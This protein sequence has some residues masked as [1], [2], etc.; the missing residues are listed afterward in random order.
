MA[1]LQALLQW[2]FL[3]VEGLFNAAFGDRLNPLYHLGAITFFLFWLVAGSGLYLYAFFETGVAAAYASMEAITHGQWFAGGILRSLH[4]YASDAMVLTMLLHLLRHFA[5]DRFRGYR[6]F[7]WATGV[8]L[9]WLV[10]ASGINGYMLPWDRLAQFVITTT[11]EWLD[12]LPGLGG[13]LMRNFTYVSSVSDRFFSLLSFL[14]IG[15]PLF[16]LLLM[17][18]HVQRVPKAA[19]MPPRPVAAGLAVALLALALVR[20]ALSQGGAADLANAVAAVDLDWFYL[21]LLPLVVAWTP[22]QVWLLAGAGSLLLVL[23]P[24]WPAGRAA[25]KAEHQ[26]VVHGAGGAQAR[27]RVRAGE[28]L[29]DAGLRQGLA[30]PYECRNG[31]CGVCICSVVQGRVAHRPYQR[32]ALPDAALADGRALLCCA[33]PLEDVGIE[34]DAVLQAA[35][36]QAIHTARVEAMERLAPDVMRLWLALPP[37]ERVPFTAGQYINILLDDGQRRAFSF[38]NAPHQDQRIELH[39]RRIPGGRFTSHVFDGMRVGDTLR[40][41]GPLGS[42]VLHEGDKP[43]LLVAAATGFAPIKSIVEDAFHRGIRRPMRLYWG[44]RR[45]QDLYLQELVQGWERDHA[46][47]RA[48]PVVSEP[49][50]SDE[51]RGRTGLV[52]E[53]MLADF[54]DLSGHQVYVCGSARMADAA[55]QAFLSRGLDEGACFSD[56]FLPAMQN[57]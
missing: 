43:I 15:L 57:V 35:V 36:A 51:W 12:A 26:A 48:V 34:V 24:W 27:V 40:F 53:A 38:A 37:G 13:T 44:V 4:R 19:T 17:W 14:H 41:E 10:Y 46:G 56:L 47:F 3:R 29:L 9:V 45:P 1:R 21:A 50:P 54:P 49:Q 30:L 7:S 55:V 6:W 23:L 20:P 25:R 5:F 11:F 39:V 33:E 18:V 2:L 22:A 42:F 16:V 31:G 28:T 52:H 32:V 8:A